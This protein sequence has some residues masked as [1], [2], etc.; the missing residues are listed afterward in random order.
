MKKLLYIVGALVLLAVVAFFVLAFSLGSIVKGGVNKMGPR[1][2]Q[3]PVHLETAKIS[4]FSGQGTLSNLTVGNPAG[5]TSERAFAL[6]QISIHVDTASLRSDHI[7]VNSI[8]IDQPEITYET[9]LTTSNLQD[10]LKN[11]Q[12][13][14]GTPNQETAEKSG[15]PVKIEIKSFRLQNARI[16]AIAA[17]NT[18]TV[19]M[20]PL[21]MENLGT[22]EGGLTPE[23]LS[24]AIMK[25]V[26]S[27]AIQAAAKV[28]VEKGLLQKGLNKL[29]GGE[30]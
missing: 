16:T 5:W 26:T 14:A 30:K 4:P 18:A 7:V 12:Q 3:S 15:K 9:R 28:A 20:P 11:I 22:R 29:L 6:G 2:T 10:L 21:V 25:E 27:Q 19:E 17:G 23:Q 8:V 1:I 24:V 13:A